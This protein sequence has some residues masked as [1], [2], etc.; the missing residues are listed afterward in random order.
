VSDNNEQVEQSLTMWGVHI[1]AQMREHPTIA[2]DPNGDLP[3]RVTSTQSVMVLHHMDGA[4]RSPEA[5][6]PWI[7]GAS[8]L[9]RLRELLYF[10]E[11]RGMIPPLRLVEPA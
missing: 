7:I 1:S 11:Q 10:A 6:E 2:F 8:D 5:G 4:P 9:E 3:P